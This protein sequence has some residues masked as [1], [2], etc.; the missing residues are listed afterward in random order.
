MFE[1]TKV[2]IAAEIIKSTICVDPAPKPGSG[3][4]NFLKAL[5]K[6]MGN[7]KPYRLN[8]FAQQ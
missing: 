1:N 3:I 8:Y 5:K 4:V 7:F 6:D 2:A